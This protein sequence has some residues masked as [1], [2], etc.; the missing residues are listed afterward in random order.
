MVSHCRQITYLQYYFAPKL[1]RMEV[2]DLEMQDGIDDKGDSSSSP[3]HHHLRTTTVGDNTDGVGLI[4]RY[5]LRSNDST[6]AG[7]DEDDLYNITKPSNRYVRLLQY[8]CVSVAIAALLYFIIAV[9]L[10]EV[11]TQYMQIAFITSITISLDSTTRFRQIQWIITAGCI[12]TLWVMLWA[13]T[14]PFS[15]IS[16][17]DLLIST[18]SGFFYF[19]GILSMTYKA[20]NAPAEVKFVEI[21]LLLYLLSLNAICLFSPNEFNNNLHMI[22]DIRIILL[23]YTCVYQPKQKMELLRIFKFIIIII[24]ILISFI[25]YEKGNN[26][27]NTI[28]NCLYIIVG[29]IL[30][31]ESIYAKPIQVITKDSL[32]KLKM[33]FTNNVTSNNS[34]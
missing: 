3:H 23:L 13:I 26:L 30:F 20:L 9:Q 10:Y 14:T 34:L 27:L 21:D 24:F 15:S 12:A 25:I 22:L 7:F 31:Y 28:G 32:T 8:F 11:A 19:G 29:M 2:A 4:H 33:S 18:I 1:M 16:L 5:F 6:I 17:L